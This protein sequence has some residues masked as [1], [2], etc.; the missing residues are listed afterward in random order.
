[1]TNFVPFKVMA[2][3]QQIEHLEVMHGTASD[4]IPVYS[5]S[6]DRLHSLDHNHPEWLDKPHT[7]TKER[8]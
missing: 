3:D 7:H 2:H 6:R 1:M 5:P 8:K 4:E